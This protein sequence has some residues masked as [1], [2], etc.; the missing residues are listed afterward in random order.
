MCICIL[1]RQP[2][3]STCIYMYVYTLFHVVYGLQVQL[4]SGCH[5][6]Q[7]IGCVYLSNRLLDTNIVGM[8]IGLVVSKLVYYVCVALHV[9]Q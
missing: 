9:I 8:L 3:Y 5:W 2:I 4:N 6:Q 1:L 7:S